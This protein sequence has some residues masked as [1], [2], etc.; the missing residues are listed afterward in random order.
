V[1]IVRAAILAL[2]LCCGAAWSGEPQKPKSNRGAQQ[3][4]AEQRGTES[5]P[6]FV[7]G[8]VTT[9]KDK[10]EADND[11]KEREVKEETD[12]SLVKY[13]G[14]LALFTLLLFVFT[15]GLFAVTF[16]LSRD[17]KA[18][19]DEHAGKMEKSITEAGRA[20]NAMEKVAKAT[21][22]NAD[23]FQD[24]MRTQFR[25]YVS[26][27]WVKALH[28]DDGFVFQMDM[29]FR[30]DGLTPAKNVS[31]SMRIDVLPAILPADFDFAVIEP[32][33]HDATMAPR[34]VF[35]VQQIMRRLPDEESEQAF[36]QGLKSLYA[37]GTVQYE[38]IFGG[39]RATNFC[40]SVHFLR[41]NDEDGKPMVRR[42]H[43]YN[44]KHNDST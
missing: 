8:E 18:T 38:D 32:S 14:Y 19:G 4:T 41:F 9:K 16:R 7:K 37:W 39:K 5:A 43:R 29:N 35:S 22:D 33:L 34:Q 42:V 24:M 10:T 15:A 44:Q 21:A 13:T 11:A 40:H 23:R 25:A 27:E 26:V 3:S 17:A 12:A 30:N 28:Q 1:L 2:V 36:D 31:Y 6:V 20:A